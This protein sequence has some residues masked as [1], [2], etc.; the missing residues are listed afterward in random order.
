MIWLCLLLFIVIFSISLWIFHC[1]QK[2]DKTLSIVEALCITSSSIFGMV[3]WDAHEFNSRDSGR[4][5]L[6]IVFISGSVFFY[7]YG[8]FLTSSLA[9]P[10]ENLPFNSP[11]ELLKTNY[12]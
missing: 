8:G 11:E 3:I 9:I 5:A 7:I 1:Y 4:C 2:Q 10:N 12:R 6:F